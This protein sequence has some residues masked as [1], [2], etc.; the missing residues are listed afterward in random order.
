MNSDMRGHSLPELLI[1]MTLG[2]IVIASA[3]TAYGLSRQ[4]WRAMAAADSV[5]ANARVALRNIREQALMAGAGYLEISANNASISSVYPI[6]QPAVAGV[7]GSKTVESVTL[8]YWHALDAI[9]CLGNLNSTAAV[10][11]NDYKLNT[12]QELTCKDLN[13]PSSSYQALAE[14]VEDFQ[15]RYAQASASAQTIQWKT[16]NQVTAMSDVV[17][18]EVCLRMASTHVVQGA[19]K[20]ATSTKGCQNESVAADGH[21]RRVFKR[22]TYLRN[23]SAQ[24]TSSVVMP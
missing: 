19:M 17:A 1:G 14:G 22:V 5:H 9:D 6:T 11:R 15:V 3:T 2:L 21:L 12:N 13:G 10:I 23:R 8:S 18:I 7:N 20:N 16:A 4:S 24:S